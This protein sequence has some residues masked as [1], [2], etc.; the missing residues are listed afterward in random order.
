M[1]VALPC[2]AKNELL[3]T[4]NVSCYV[5]AMYLLCNCSVV[6]GQRYDF[7]FDNPGISK[8]SKQL[9][10][11][12]EEE[13]EEDEE[14][15]SKPQKDRQTSTQTD[16]Q[17][18]T[19]THRHKHRQTERQLASQT[20][21]RQVVRQTGRKGTQTG[22]QTGRQAGAV[23]PAGNKANEISMFWQPWEIDSTESKVKSKT[24]VYQSDQ[25]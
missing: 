6:A 22:R 4:C 24:V 5:I 17:T 1:N 12:E 13:A 21:S 14:H 23:E 9:Q 18:E 8:T 19:Q 11:E 10:S 7:R 2:E 3:C 20:S 25:M 15:A 16:K